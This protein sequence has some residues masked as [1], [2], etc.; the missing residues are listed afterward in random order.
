MLPDVRCSLL[1]SITRAIT[2]SFDLDD[3]LH[4]LLETVSSVVPFDAGGIFILRRAFPDVNAPLPSHRIAGMALRG[5]PERPREDDAMLKSGRGIVG[6]VIRT[7]GTIIAPDVRDHPHYVEARA[8]TRSEIAV[9]IAVH[10]Q[11]IGA[12]N[13]ESDHLRAF[14]RTDAEILEFI[15]GAA[16]LMIERTLLNRELLEK[17]GLDSQLEIAR[18]VQSS[19]LPDGPPEL[20][21]YEMAAV[22]IPN[23]QVGGDYYDYIPLQ[24]RRLA[25]AIADVSGKGIPAALV[26][27]SFRAALR[28]QLGHDP[29]VA[30]AMT[31]VNAF[32]VDFL[33]ESEFVTAF[34]AAL[35]L[36]DGR[37]EYVNGGHNPP[38]LLR[39]GGGTEMLEA[40]G[41]ILGFSRDSF[42][43]A[44][45]VEMR[46]GDVLV[47]YTDG[48]IEAR[49]RA[50]EEFGVARLERVLR[51]TEAA[52]IEEVVR[53]VVA[54]GRS[55]SETE[56]FDDDLTLVVLR[57]RV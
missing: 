11:V 20:E 32:L 43:D 50:G 55:F 15:A 5:Y 19:L 7:G 47:L 53:A 34:C 30:G 22:N 36:S 39:A 37:L 28:T 17:K 40:G 10:G 38:L 4:E 45:E 23:I 6:Q 14:S 9:P 16:A 25:V 41:M 21:D 31:A 42:Y 44:G 35:K 46:P 57:R 18:D 54:A 3:V 29:D 8:T 51:E 26:M 2:T 56:Q 1:L 33:K 13:L 24:R 49:N 52:P 27:A 12:L 48:V